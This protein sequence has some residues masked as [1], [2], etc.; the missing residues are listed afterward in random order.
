MDQQAQQAQQT[1]IDR[2]QKMER[3]AAESDNLRQ[4]YPTFDLASEMQNERFKGMLSRGASLEEAYEYAHM[5][6]LISGG[7][8]YA[9]QKAEEKVTA[10]VQ[11]N[12][13]RPTEAGM[14]SSAVA[15]TSY[16]DFANMKRSDFN[17][18]VR[19]VKSGRRVNF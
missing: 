11:A 3:I 17:K 14:T 5:S 1:E 16:P 9:A 19:E 15:A 6:E 12:R 2:Q 10:T 7:M 4:K 13:S 18:L 8:K